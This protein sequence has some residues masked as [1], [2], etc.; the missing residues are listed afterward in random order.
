MAARLS[1]GTCPEVG[2]TARSSN[3]GLISSPRLLFC[4]CCFR[5]PS[6]F[7]S[8]YNVSLYRGMDGCGTHRRTHRRRCVGHLPC[9]L[10]VFVDDSQRNLYSDKDIKLKQTTHKLSI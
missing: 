9:C 3:N 7:A 2:L 5:Q 6:E 10:C 8:D 4:A 1:G